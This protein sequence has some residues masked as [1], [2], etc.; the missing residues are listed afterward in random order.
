MEIVNFKDP[1]KWLPG[2]YCHVLQCVPTF[3]FFK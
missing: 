3:F 2:V 1:E